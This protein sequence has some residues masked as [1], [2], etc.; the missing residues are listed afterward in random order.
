MTN[1]GKFRGLGGGR[2]GQKKGVELIFHTHEK[3]TQPYVSL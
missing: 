2:K 1:K 3:I